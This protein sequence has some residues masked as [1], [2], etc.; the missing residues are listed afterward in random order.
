MQ[1]GVWFQRKILKLFQ[2]LLLL[3]VFF[4]YNLGHNFY[5]HSGV[6]IEWVK[7]SRE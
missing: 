3:Q 1:Y 4:I 5:H 6:K 2:A 7:I